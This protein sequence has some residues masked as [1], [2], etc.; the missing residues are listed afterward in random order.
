MEFYNSMS[1]DFLHIYHNLDLEDH[2]HS[3]HHVNSMLDILA[4]Q[5]HQYKI[6]HLNVIS[7][8]AQQLIHLNTHFFFLLDNQLELLHLLVGLL[9]LD[10]HQNNVHILLLLENNDHLLPFFYNY[11]QSFY[12]HNH[13]SNLYH[14]HLHQHHHNYFLV[15]VVTHIVI[16]QAYQYILDLY[17]DYLVVQIHI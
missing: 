7:Y 9:N 8:Q 10:L 3:F 13:T 17:Q 15:V 12:C 6:H 2:I 1:L 11:L 5:Y 4:Y 14:K 16:V